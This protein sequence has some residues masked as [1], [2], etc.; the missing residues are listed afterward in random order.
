MKFSSE[1]AVAEVASHFDQ[2]VIYVGLFVLSFFVGLQVGSIG[3]LDTYSRL[4]FG[5][6]F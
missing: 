4:C 3:S 6:P 2:V 5:R 1:G